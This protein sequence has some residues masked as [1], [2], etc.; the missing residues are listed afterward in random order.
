MV[1]EPKWQPWQKASFMDDSDRLTWGFAKTRKK[2]CGHVEVGGMIIIWVIWYH[3]NSICHNI[4]VFVE[5]L[6]E[7]GVML[8]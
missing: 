1:V 6:F 7:N 2:Y 5:H 4:V 3:G 8:I